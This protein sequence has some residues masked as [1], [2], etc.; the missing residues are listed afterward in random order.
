MRFV[1]GVGVRRGGRD[2]GGIGCIVKGDG[3]IRENGKWREKNRVSAE[4]QVYD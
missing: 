1:G 4:M 2:R 3:V